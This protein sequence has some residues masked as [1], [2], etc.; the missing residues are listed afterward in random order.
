MYK[1]RNYILS[2]VL[3]TSHQY[4]VKGDIMLVFRRCDGIHY[5]LFNDFCR[6]RSVAVNTMDKLQ[7]L[8]L[9]KYKAPL[10]SNSNN[11]LQACQHI[12]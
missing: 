4:L 7:F 10:I 5:H 3:M 2:I 8:Y 1:Y 12:I 9:L 11:F 6:F